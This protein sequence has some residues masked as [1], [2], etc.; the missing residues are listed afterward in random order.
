MFP[1]LFTLAAVLCVASSGLAHEGHGHPEHTDGVLHY[2]VNPSHSVSV[3]AAA[4]VAVAFCVGL[5]RL[6]AAR[7]GRN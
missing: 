6:M 5:R 1:R 7:S 3:V 4:V 2:V